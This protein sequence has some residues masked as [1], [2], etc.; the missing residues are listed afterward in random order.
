VLG[1]QGEFPVPAI[2]VIAALGSA[3]VD[4]LTSWRP[5]S[6]TCTSWSVRPIPWIR[7]GGERHCLADTPRYQP[8]YAGRA[9]L[10][11]ACPMRAAWE[12]RL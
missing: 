5:A 2:A 3:F 10:T 7:S 9:G 1:A 8:L 12:S 6:A 11:G 4:N